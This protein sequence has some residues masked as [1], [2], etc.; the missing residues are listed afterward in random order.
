MTSSP[1]P[2]P[3]ASSTST[4]ASV[5]LATP[6]VLGTPRWRAASS[7][8]ARTFGPRMKTPDSSTSSRRRRSSSRS[9]AYCA[10]TSTCG[11]AATRARILACLQPPAPHEA[12]H[13]PERSD[14]DEDE[15]D[16]VDVVER[17]VEPVP[18]R[19]DR[20]ADAGEGEAPEGRADERQQRV[21]REPVA[22][23]A[24]RDRDEGADERS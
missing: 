7:S 13:D 2:T 9:G 15:H 18:V 3:S 17:P 16:D 1:S 14:D 21:A 10:F 23:D 22:E 19:A 8:N 5:P 12:R 4:S 20:P 11:I 6:I 24:G